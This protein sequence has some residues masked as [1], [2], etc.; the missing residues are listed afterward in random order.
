MFQH[1]STQ[2]SLFESQFQ[3]SARKRERL[4]HTWAQLFRERCLPL[5]NEDLFCALY[6]EDNGAPC[7]SVRL[8]VGTLILQALFDQTD[9][10][11][12]AAVDFNLQWHL[13][14]G[15][16]PCDDADY[17]SQRTLQYFRAKLLTHEIAYLLFR[18][19]TDRLIALLG[20]HTGQQR[21][22]STHLL[23]NFALRSRLGV[24]CETHRVFLRALRGAGEAW[25]AQVPPSLRQRYL[26]DE[27]V[28]SHYDDAR[29]SEC[30]RRLDVA[31]RDAYRLREAFRGVALPAKVAAVYALEER[32][33]AE[34]C[35]LVTE[36]QPGVAGDG[37]SD[38]PPVPVV[39]KAAKTLTPDCLQTPHDPDVTYSGHKGQGYEALLV[40]T[41]DP[42]NP[43]QL[44]TQVSLER[45]CEGDADRVLPAVQVL[46][47]RGLKP[48]SLLG[49]TSFGSIG[50]VVACACL[51]VELVAPQPG[52]APKAAPPVP[53]FMV[54]ERD[55]QVQLVPS[56]LPSRCP[57]GVLALGTR[58]QQDIPEAGPVAFLQM[59]TASCQSCPRG[60]WCPALTLETGETMVVLRLKELLPYWR[61]ATENT[62][63]FRL[64]YNG[65]A[66]IEG[67][68]SELKR[69]QGLGKLRVRGTPRVRLALVLRSLACNLKRGMAYWGKTLGKTQTSVLVNG[70]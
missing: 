51:G 41:C 3:L 53:E 11:A 33:V 8:I 1:S 35:T 43:V 23:S 57:A 39:P 50:N 52:T 42:T 62:E 66:G 16:D 5:I 26:D 44:I 38:L 34:H 28:N 59:P 2:G 14:L 60:A 70:I 46:E 68:N 7:K 64:R 19:L 31:A 24:F 27:G 32:L 17:I 9:A 63:T 18:D 56:A 69:G 47:A 55:F 25:L 65:R 67:T 13:A 15:L 49:D 40:E 45:S 10:E 37:D 4:E 12:Q 48:E 6:C 58:L 29:S 30:R 20:V 21:L 61:R 36:P 22:D 54:N